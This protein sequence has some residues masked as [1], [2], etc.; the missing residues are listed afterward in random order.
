LAN[1]QPVGKRLRFHQQRSKPTMDELH[2]WLEAQL[3]EHK[4]E[5]N[6][7]LGK[8]ITYLLRHRKALTTFLQE[9]RGP[10]GQQ[11]RKEP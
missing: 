9:R 2:Q 8:A 1:E 10:A 5:P 7:G 4:T 3:A 11:S 6:S